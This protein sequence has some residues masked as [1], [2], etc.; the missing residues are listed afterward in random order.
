MVLLLGG[1]I[2]GF[3]K[4]RGSYMVLLRG[5]AHTCFR[6]IRYE[7]VHLSHLQQN[8]AVQS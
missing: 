5:G 7:K 2:H 8:L 4:G 3:V 1:L 6:C